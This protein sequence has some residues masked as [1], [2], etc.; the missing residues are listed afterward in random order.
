VLLTYTANLGNLNLDD[1]RT[2]YIPIHNETKI[3]LNI[4]DNILLS[5]LEAQLEQIRI[6]FDKNYLH[7]LP[8]FTI[9]LN[10][11]LNLTSLSPVLASREMRALHGFLVIQASSYAHL[12]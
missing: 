2:K 3:E 6:I 8:D 1:M 7:V 11:K 4:V 9:Q 10:N 5:E 12:N